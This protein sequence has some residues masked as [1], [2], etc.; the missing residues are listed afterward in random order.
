MISIERDKNDNNKIPTRTKR[1]ISN[2]TNT[3]NKDSYLY[4]IKLKKTYS[5][6]KLRE[7]NSTSTNCIHIKNNGNKRMQSKDMYLNKK[8]LTMNNFYPSQ[9]PIK[10]Q[11]L[12]PMSKNKSNFSKKIRTNND[13]NNSNKTNKLNRNISFSY[14]NKNNITNNNTNCILNNNNNYDIS[15]ILKV[16]KKFNQTCK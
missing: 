9:N 8:N 5:S 6:N 12:S 11:S 16:R 10:N 7:E 2:I 14:F 3:D 13:I 1:N 4:L 15:E